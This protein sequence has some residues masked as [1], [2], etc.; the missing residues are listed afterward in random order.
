MAEAVATPVRDALPVVQLEGDAQAE[1]EAAPLKDFEALLQALLQPLAL[2]KL[3]PVPVAQGESEDPS[4]PVAA[5]VAL[6]TE[7]LAVGDKDREAV[8]QAQAEPVALDILLL[9]GEVVEKFELLLCG[10]GLA[11]PLPL[12]LSEPLAVG[13]SNAL[14]LAKLDPLPLPVSRALGESFGENKAL[15]LEELVAMGEPLGAP[16]PHALP[17]RDAAAVAQLVK[18]AQAEAVATALNELVVLLQ[19]VLHPLALSVGEKVAVTVLHGEAEPVVLGM[20]LPLG[21]ALR[22]PEFV[23][24]ALHVPLKDAVPRAL[25]VP[26]TTVPLTVTLLDSAAVSLRRALP[27]PHPLPLLL[28]RYDPV[29]LVVTVA[30]ECA[31]SLG[32]GVAE[33]LDDMLELMRPLLL[34][35]VLGEMVPEPDDVAQPVPMALTEEQAVAVKVARVVPETASLPDPRAVAQELP[36]FEIVVL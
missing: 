16:V 36:L 31:L 4:V 13:L 20:L 3:L 26:A 24:L 25:S 19:A 27:L 17:L 22:A 8:P 15:G 1:E 2:A 30:V 33:A 21:E 7:A 18:D 5:P 9:L 12:G 6:T 35:Q 10:V 14:L 11:A 28:E 23:S 29:T 32:F 34:A